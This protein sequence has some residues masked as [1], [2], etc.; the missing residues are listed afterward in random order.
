METLILLQANYEEQV[1]AAVLGKVIGVYMGRPFEGQ[2]R[3]DIEARF[4]EIDRYVA[5]ECG[6]PLVVADDDISGTFTFVKALSDFGGDP[7]DVPPSFFGETWRNYLLEKRTILWWGGMSLSTEHTAWLRLK[8]GVPSPESGSAR[9]N[10]KVVSEQIGAQIF[11]DAFGMVSPGAPDLAER[12]ADGAA[13]VSHD[14]EA[15]LAAKVVARMV[16][17]AFVEKDMAKVL[18]IGAAT[19][20]PDSLVAQVHRDVRA[21]ARVDRDWRATYDRIAAKYGYDKYGGNCHVIPNHALMVMAWSYAGNDFFEAQRI[22]NTA[23]WDTDCN[24]ANVGTVSALVAGLD[25]ICDRYDFRTPFADR[26]IIPTADGTDTVTDCRLVARKIAALGRRVMGWPEPAGSPLPRHAFDLPGTFHGW[27][28][29]QNAQCT[30]L[31]A[32]CS[33]LVTRHLSLVTRHSS[34]VTPCA[35]CIRFSGPTRIS[36]PVSIP[37]GQAGSYSTPNA[38][39]LYPGMTATVRGTAAAGLPEGVVLRAFAR[40]SGGALSES[41]PLPLRPEEPFVLRWTIDGP[42]AAILDFGLAVE[43]PDGAE[44]ELLLDSVEYGGEVRLD[45]GDAFN[46]LRGV[47]PIDGWINGMDHLRGMFSDDTEPQLHM[48]SDVDP[49]CYVTGNRDWGDETLSCRFSVHAAD[50]AGVVLRWQGMRRHYAFLF[51]KGR[52]L[53]VRQHYGETILAECPFAI[54]E[55]RMF[56]L[57]ARAEGGH[58]SLSLD[59]ETLLEADDD[60]FPTGGVGFYAERGLF[61]VAKVAIRAELAKRAAVDTTL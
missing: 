8:Q 54:P 59:G 6:V 21:W 22:V 9:L 26:L 5:A 14:G 28:A 19:L 23:G 13:R 57:V 32:Q 24:A 40:H 51:E 42:G 18:D 3:R 29:E 58:L 41:V 7:R 52:A 30:M 50:R 61:G 12:F 55:N 38:P 10:G 4:G 15:V 2:S 48:G 36:T 1:Y 35:L 33:P 46:P 20:P 53:L 34:L 44:G 16:A 37:A 60:A 25:H 17:A 43:A 49:C 56:D 47:S 11:I 39:W 31:N 27:Q 45:L